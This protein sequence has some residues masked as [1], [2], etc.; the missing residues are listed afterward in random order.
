M[1]SKDSGDLLQVLLFLEVERQDGAF[2]TWHSIHGVGH[3]VFQLSALQN[4][5]RLAFFRFRHISQQL[6]FGESVGDLIQAP[7]AN[8]THVGQGILILGH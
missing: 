5:P 4:Y 2:E 3:Q 6:T 1:N 8:R 7:Q